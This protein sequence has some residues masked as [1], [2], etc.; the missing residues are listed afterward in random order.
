MEAEDL[1]GGI[2]IVARRLFG[3]MCL[4]VV[5]AATAWA[6]DSVRMTWLHH[7]LPT[8]GITATGAATLHEYHGRGHTGRSIEY[9][10]EVGGRT[11]T[12]E[13]GARKPGWA[14][15]WDQNVF[16]DAPLAA[17]PGAHYDQ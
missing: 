14:E 2:S 17:V 10:F 11:F 6:I 15:R 3:V 1:E 16:G 8:R 5:A 7:S 13:A 4:L 9:R 12:G